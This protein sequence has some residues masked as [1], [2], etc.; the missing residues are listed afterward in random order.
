VDV[1]SRGTPGCAL[2]LGPDRSFGSVTLTPAHISSPWRELTA[3]GRPHLDRA[4]TGRS[5]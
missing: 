1:I 4:P 5:R 2:V 3:A